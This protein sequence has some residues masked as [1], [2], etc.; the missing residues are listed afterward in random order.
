MNQIDN[1]LQELRIRIGILDDRIATLSDS[2]ELTR[3]RERKN[4]LGDEFRRAQLQKHTES[5]CDN[6]P[7][8]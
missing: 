2:P 6:T 5:M 7:P 4:E 3:T 1:Y 8:T